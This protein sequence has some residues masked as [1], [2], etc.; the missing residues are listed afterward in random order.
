MPDKL[1][2]GSSVPAA[3]AGG[4]PAG[5][6]APTP[7]TP[8]P[9]GAAGFPAA[10]RLRLPNGMTIVTQSRVEAGH[11]FEDLFVKR[12][13]LRHGLT[14]HPG[15]C[16]FD[17]GGNIG[18]FALFA[19]WHAPGARIYTFE[20]APPLFRRLCANLA[21]NGAAAR[22]F[23]HG[24]ADAERTARFT[25]YP[26]SSGMS[27][28]YADPEEERAVLRA[29]MDRRR[30]EGA[31]EMDALMEYAEELLDER[32]RAEE[33]ECRLRP[34]SAV[35][36]EEGVERIDFLKV[37]VQKAEMDVLR[38][39]ADHDW[40][41][42][43]QIA[44]EVHDLDGRLEAVARLLEGRGFRVA[45]EQDEA[46]EGSVL[47]NLFAVNRR[48]PRARDPLRGAG[49]A[50]ACPR[51]S[52]GAAGREAAAGPAPFPAGAESWQLL[53]LSAA[54]RPG[55]DAGAERLARHLSAHPELPPAGAA[56]AGSSRGGDLAYRRA[57][58]VGAGDD[59][60][61]RLRARDPAWTSEGVVDGSGRSV[62]FLFP[63]VGEQ[64]P[65]MGRGVYETEPVFRAELDRCAVHLRTHLG[66]DLRDVLFAADREPPPG[67]PPGG[68]DL[69]RMLG[70]APASGA[71]GLLHRTDVA[72][73]VA[74]AVGYALARLWESWGVRAD[75]VA[76]HS[77][78]EYTA[79]CVAGVFSLEDALALVALRARAI[80]ELPPGAMLAVSLAPD[81]LGPWLAEDVALA[82]VNAPGL[83][84][85]SGAE[86]AITR[87]EKS[88]AGSGHAVRRLA[89]TH[90]FHSPL[91]QPVADRVAALA[92]GMRLRAP[93]IPML[94]NVTGS[95]LSA[96]EATDPHYWARHLVRTVRF[97]AGAAELLAQ[98][99]R[100]LV[101][102]GPGGSLGTFV[103]QQAAASG[104]EPPVGVASLPHGADD[105]PEPAFLLGALGRLWAA[106]V[107]PDWTA[108]GGG[109]RCHR[110]PLPPGPDGPA[111]IDAASAAAPAPGAPGAMA[112][113][114]ERGREGGSGDGGDVARVLAGVW[115]EL[116]NVQP[117]GDDDFFLLGG[118]SLVAT[119]LIARVRERFGVEMR[120]RTIF[121][122]R[123][124]SA[125]A[126]WIEDATT[127]DR[128]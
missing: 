77:L 42:I 67:A 12:V 92:A 20:P 33:M 68:L 82:A 54:T 39:I 99:G 13:Y 97:A 34:L 79:A 89:A 110:V 50:D 5:A 87:V 91:L 103:R 31:A 44:M 47:H 2:S 98:P 107:R 59:A 76:G 116:L 120:L 118:H 6:A 64:Y 36:R 70:R 29:M 4:V 60:C 101:E 45:V 43:R 46:V 125:M 57:V 80:Q 52:T 94:S 102:A 23:N 56:L 126:R 7:A 66:W 115:S 48:M 37:D 123:T 40:P 127:P 73:P 122:T 24:I 26:G 9:A 72:Q 117:R 96:A 30:R 10:E 109:R 111:G 85:L 65:G 108:A 17:V 128:S 16:V 106:G 104:A 113:A 93:R 19:H 22:T 14:L 105:T 63:G 21:L 27:S 121:Q 81:A 58:V 83:S 86:E 75:V 35:I 18:M 62:V 41:R 1:D 11:F 25:F 124:V 69:R 100:V 90:A 32:F 112:G 51:V 55:L 53:L 88:L 28:F 3:I 84:V 74:F 15:D 8:D 61:A 95:W 78:G 49:T 119:R 114:E 38:G 71:A